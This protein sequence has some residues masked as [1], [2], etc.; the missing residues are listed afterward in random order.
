LHEVMN[1]HLS[2][3]IFMLTAL[4]FVGLDF[5]CAAF[6]SSKNTL[7]ITGTGSSIGPMQLMAVGFKK[8]YPNVNV[9]VLPSIG[10]TG[11]IR[12]V[13]EGKI[14][15]GLSAR[16]LKPEERRGGITQEIYGRTAFIFGVQDSNPV[17]GFTLREIEDIYS[18]KRKNWSDGT[19]IRLILRPL[20]DAY[21]AYLVSINP[22]I[23]SAYE[24][25]HAVPDVFVGNT[26]Q[27]AARQI[28][29]TPGSFGT[30]SSSVIAAEQR[31]I[32]ALS[33]D[34]TAP[35]LADVATGKYPYVMTLLMVYK[36]EQYSGLIKDFVE[37][38]FSGDG[39]KILSDSGHVTFHRV[40][41]K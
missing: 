18:G 26:D 37:F 25:A 6:A 7:M 36:Q 40:T 16:S 28:E 12:A 10:S 32:K 5:S 8:K 30:T 2:Y 13:R 22:G 29:K 15:I 19:P 27:E 11:G 38:V 17:K 24:K 23:K 41:G 21:S 39:Q 33:V 14:D 31:K 4:L 35:T 34:G 3:R 20:S 1:I 9:K